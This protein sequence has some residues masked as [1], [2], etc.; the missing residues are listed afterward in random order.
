[1]LNNKFYLEIGMLVGRFLVKR[2][3]E[4]TKKLIIQ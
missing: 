1:M 2:S 4:V 3:C